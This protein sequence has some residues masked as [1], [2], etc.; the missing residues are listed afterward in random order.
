MNMPAV[1]VAKTEAV[2]T[3]E[4]ATEAETVEVVGSKST[5][6]RPEPITESS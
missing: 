4:V 5:D 1:R 3:A 2:E 6:R